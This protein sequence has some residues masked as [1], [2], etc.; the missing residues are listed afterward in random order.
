MARSQSEA[1]R[2]AAASPRRGERP[3]LTA[4][5]ARATK[6]ETRV[7]SSVLPGNTPP[8]IDSVV[9]RP[10]SPSAQ[11]LIQIDVAAS[12]AEDEVQRIDV[13]ATPPDDSGAGARHKIGTIAGAAGT[14]YW[15]TSDVNQ[16]PDG[17]HR[18]EIEA[19]DSDSTL[20]G[21]GKS[22]RDYTL[23]RTP[24]VPVT[25]QEPSNPT[26]GENGWTIV[27]VRVSLSA[28]DATSAVRDLRFYWDDPSTEQQ[29]EGD[30]PVP[31]GEHVLY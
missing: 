9:F 21:A 14:V 5:R 17:Q 23:D 16:Y 26:L 10:E 18:I 22:Q 2:H 19:F 25:R 11:S 30:F 27:P 24:P 12:D 6:R 15:S 8:R 28:E 13:Y 3:G 20:F 4:T 1:Q 31:E 29:Y 7:R